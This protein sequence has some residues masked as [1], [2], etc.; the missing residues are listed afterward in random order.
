MTLKMFFALL[1]VLTVSCNIVLIAL[2]WRI[3]NTKPLLQLAKGAINEDL[4]HQERSMIKE[5][6]YVLKNHGQ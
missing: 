3:N 5:T 4:R 2:L 6:C 1:S